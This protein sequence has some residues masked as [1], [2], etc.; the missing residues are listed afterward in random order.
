[1]QQTLLFLHSIFRWL[2]LLSLLLAVYKA[3]QGYHS[4]LVFTSKTNRIR[5]LTATITHIQLI[6]GLVLYFQSPAVKQFLAAAGRPERITE[7]L[8][9]GLIHISMMIT[10]VFIVT[11]GSALSKRQPTDKEKFK[12]MFIWFFI[13]LLIILIAVPW[14][15]SPLIQRP[16]IRSI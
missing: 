15:F 6:I 12:I 9:F 10:A 7:P 5:H 8:F 16:F 11:T 2:V 1:M 13:A 4:G 14:P 3:F